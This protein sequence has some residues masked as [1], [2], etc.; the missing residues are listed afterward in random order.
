M[1]YLLTAASVALFTTPA[2]ALEFSKTA[3]ETTLTQSSSDGVTENVFSIQG[4]ASFAHGLTF[5]ELSAGLV[6][7]KLTAGPFEETAEISTTSL[8]VGTSVSGIWDLYARTSIIN[9]SLEDDFR[10]S[11]TFWGLGAQINL[12]YGEYG[13]EFMTNSSGDRIY[14][15]AADVP[16]SDTVDV[17]GYWRNLDDDDPVDTQY[18]V[19]LDVDRGPFSGTIGYMD[20]DEGDKLAGIDM[21]Y[22]LSSRISAKA[23][24]ARFFVEDPVT[25]VS[26]GLGYQLASNAS[27]EARIGQFRPHAGDNATTVG[28]AMRFD[29]YDSR[30]VIKRA[31][32][33]F[34]KISGS[35]FT[36][37]ISF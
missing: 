15:A 33:N 28:I 25:Y 4:K 1:R 35:L 14:T 23:N 10:D 6:R 21:S 20:L 7:Q 31:E 30:R 2:V 8:V 36:N 16:I 27:I 3:V 34:S 13:F 22:D 12:R 19:I 32:D 9:A 18:G 26:V 24:L 37:A 5:G 29:T 11:A 17:Y